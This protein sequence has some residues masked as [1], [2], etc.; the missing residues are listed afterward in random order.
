[1]EWKED[2]T[3]PFIT[4]THRERTSVNAK[5]LLSSDIS[6]S[7]WGWGVDVS[8]ARPKERMTGQSIMF[9]TSPLTIPSFFF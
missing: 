5:A 7:V 4:T 1:M 8:Q 9:N 3:R 6:P 2:M